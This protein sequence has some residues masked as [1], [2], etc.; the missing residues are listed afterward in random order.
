MPA[1]FKKFKEMNYF[2]ATYSTEWFMTFFSKFP[3]RM[4]TRIIDIYLVEGPKTLFR[5]ALS[6]LKLHESEMLTADFETFYSIMAEYKETADIDE[7]TKIA[8]K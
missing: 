1:L 7:L 5:F 6:I 8:F 2:A 3:L 4:T